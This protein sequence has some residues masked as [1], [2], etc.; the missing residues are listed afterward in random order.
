MEF[1]RFLL[2]AS[3]CKTPSE[4]SVLKV[5]NQA[6]SFWAGCL[7]PIMLPTWFPLILAHQRWSDLLS[8]ILG[9]WA[10]PISGILWTNAFL[11]LGLHAPEI[12]GFTVRYEWSA[13]KPCSCQSG[14]R[15][16]GQFFW[17]FATD[18]DQMISVSMH[19]FEFF[20]LLDHTFSDPK[21]PKV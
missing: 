18:A 19:E 1:L 7:S 13:I 9:L 21:R 10:T 16:E 3:I 20:W 15:W 14:R 17:R 6:Y 8:L 4:A 12:F 2:L 11:H 5:R